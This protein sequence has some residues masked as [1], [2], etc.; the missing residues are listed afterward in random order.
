MDL[1]PCKPD[2]LARVDLDQLGCINMPDLDE[3]SRDQQDVRRMKGN[4]VWPSFPFDRLLRP[5]RFAMTAGQFWSVG[6][7]SSKGQHGIVQQTPA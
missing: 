7:P 3:L 5:I 2:I 6:I 1:L 4:T